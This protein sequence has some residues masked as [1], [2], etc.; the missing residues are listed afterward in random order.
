M[1]LPDDVP[2]A[3]PDQLLLAV[4]DPTWQK[5]LRTMTAW[6]TRALRHVRETTG[7]FN[8]VVTSAVRTHLRRQQA[9]E[10]PPPA[11]TDELWDL[12]K[13]A[14]NRKIVKYRHSGRA[15]KN[16]AVRQADVSDETQLQLW[17]AGFADHNPTP[18]QVEDYVQQ[19]L[20]VV[21]DA[22]PDPQ[23]QEIARLTLMSYLPAET[24]QQLGLSVH[25]VRR[26]L[27]DLRRLIERQGADA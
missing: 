22:T 10:A 9:G 24:A 17:E 15:R 16:Q 20:Q 3:A 1:P 12:L 8:D 23:L 4:D 6:A 21:R 25:Q 14:L 26:R 13:Q 18:E 7:D 27:E 19:A 2:R 11:N 5:Y